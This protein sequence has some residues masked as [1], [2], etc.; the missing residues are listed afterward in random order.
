MALYK[1]PANVRYVDMCIYVDENAYRT[2]L[3]EDEENKIFEYLFHIAKMLAYKA[4]Y[5]NRNEYYDDF[6][7]Y[8]A[9]NVYFRLKNPKQF[10]I[11]PET[12]EPK[13][14]KIKSCLN[15]MKNVAY[16]RKIEFEQE[17]YSQTFSP[18]ISEGDS[19]YY[20]TTYSFAD[21]LAE[22]A[23][24]INMV[25]FDICLGEICKT[26]K[27]F[28]KKIPYKSNTTTWTNIY[29]SCLLTFLSTLTLSNKS[30]EHI[31]NLKF[32]INNRPRALE[33]L[34][35]DNPENF[36]ILYHLDKNMRD[37]IWIL[38]QELKHLISKDLSLSLHTYIP[39]TSMMNALAIA[40]INLDEYTEY[41]E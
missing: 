36:V 33:K 29:L 25:E 24:E 13:L 21:K 2:D 20:D 6:A 38:V 19:V 11:D 40:D 22:V 27:N 12:N 32:D 26:I 35:S 1:K 16:L 7:V 41:G 4:K 31:N 18:V 30:I 37:Y 28:L 34:Y 39:T 9:T 8:L 10:E 15:Y 17:F 23:D 5:F 3:T 14:S